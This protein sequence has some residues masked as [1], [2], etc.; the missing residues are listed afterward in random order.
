MEVSYTNLLVYVL[1]SPFL[2]LFS[3]FGG[4]V[5]LILVPLK[6]CCPLFCVF[7]VAMW[8]FKLPVSIF[9]ELV[10]SPG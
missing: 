6:L 7:D 9:W 4:A 2:L 10:Y 3:L 5:W 1:C 8:I